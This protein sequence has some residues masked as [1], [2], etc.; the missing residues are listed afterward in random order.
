MLTNCV[1]NV[2]WKKCSEKSAGNVK[3]ML[4][5][6]LGYSKNN[7]QCGKEHLLWKYY[8]VMSTIEYL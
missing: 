7:M 8:E 1:K 4:D 5:D 2:V 6:I 3:I